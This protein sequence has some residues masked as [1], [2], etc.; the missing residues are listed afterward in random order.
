MTRRTGVPVID[1]AE[2]E[3]QFIRAS[4]PGGQNVNKVSTAVE[5][6]FDVRASKSISAPVRVR[7]ERLAGQRLTKE[8]VLVIRADRHRTQ[9]QNRA[10]ARARLQELVEQASY[11][12][13]PRV[14]TR[15]T[16]ASRER[17]HESKKRRGQVKKGRGRIS[18]GD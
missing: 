18:A 3:E 8:G 11:E 15:P 9:E 2:I 1:E 12:P 10:D 17:R 6:R 14:K 7:L 13:K 16:K 5:L 4:G